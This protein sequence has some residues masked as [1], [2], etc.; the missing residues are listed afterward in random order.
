MRRTLCRTILLQILLVVVAVPA[1]SSAAEFNPSLILTDTDLTAHQTMTVSEVRD[2]LKTQGSGLATAQ[3]SDVDGATRTA[4]EIII[5]ASEEDKINPRYLLAVLQ[6]EQSLITAKAPTQKQLDWATG[7]GVC[8]SCGLDDPAIQKFRGF[9][10]QVRRASG[11]MRYYYDNA[12]S[13]QWIKRTGQS[14]VIDNTAITPLSS[15]TAYLYTYTP[16]IAGN[17]NLWRLWHQWFTK[18][19]PDGSLLQAVDD[20]VIYLIHNGTRRPFT[21]KA[22]FVSRYTPDAVL[23][24]TPADLASYS[25]GGGIS[26]PNYSLVRVPSGMTYV[27][28]DDVKHPI[29]SQAVFKSIGYNPEEIDDVSDADIAQYL[30]GT[31][32]TTASLYPLGAI[33]QDKKTRQLYYAK[34]GIRYV[35][36]S[37]EV[38]RVNFGQKKISMVDSK[39]LAKLEFDARKVVT[40]RDGTLLS[41]KGSPYTHV[42]SNGMLRLIPNDGVFQALGYQKKNIVFT[43]EQALITIPT[44]EPLSDVASSTRVAGK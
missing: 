17:K 24:V 6:K 27:L 39:Q 15:A 44:G 35:I 28:I 34:N 7:Y 26:L 8:D 10:T 42:V 11:I 2:F 22:A 1:L 23:K 5:A 38:V 16:H 12:A 18:M 40:F 36:Q 13:Q 4:A 37:E 33:I 31:F 20:E 3:F 14:Y 43:T 32:I 41:V 19:Y 29:A 25:V 21:T 9:A 30:N